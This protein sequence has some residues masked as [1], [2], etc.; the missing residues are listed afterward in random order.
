MDSGAG[1]DLAEEGKH[2]DASVLDLYVSEAIE[3]FLVLTA[4]LTEGVEETKG[5][6]GTQFVLEG[7]EGGGG[8]LLGHGGK[9]GGAGEQGGED[10][11]LHG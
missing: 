2:T 10:S 11:S 4:Q 6:L 3:A 7:L 5:G 8:S 1:G 9:G